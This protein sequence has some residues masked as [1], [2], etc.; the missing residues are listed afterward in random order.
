MKKA[1]FRFLFASILVAVAML[2]AVV[3]R[4]SAQNMLTAASTH[5]LYGTPKAVFMGATEAEGVLNGHLN[6]LAVLIGGMPQGSPAWQVT[7]RSMIYYRT[8]L[9]GIMNGKDVA[10]AFM[11]GVRLFSTPLFSGS[12]YSEKLNLR[13]ESINLLDQ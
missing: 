10:D 4:G 9:L 8:I 6:S 3:E 1:N 2:F 7:Q 11:D 12:S 13:Q 5:E